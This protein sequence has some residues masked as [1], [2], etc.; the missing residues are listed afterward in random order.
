MGKKPYK[1]NPILESVLQLKKLEF[2]SDIKI[3]YE[4]VQKEL[5]D[6]FDLHM[7]NIAQEIIS[8]Q[9]EARKGTTYFLA[10]LLLT[11]PDEEFEGYS[12]EEKDNFYFYIKLVKAAIHWGQLKG[13][14]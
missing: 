7:N 14:K 9:R 11:L 4:Q 2:D 6:N 5:G 13:I 10:G 3:A 8:L 12:D 1:D